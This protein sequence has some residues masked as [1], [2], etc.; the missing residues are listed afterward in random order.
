MSVPS[1]WLHLSVRPLVRPLLRIG[2]RPN[3]VTVAHLALGLITLVAL[4]YGT[5]PAR[6]AAGAGWLISCLL[7]RLDGELARTGNMCSEFGHRLDYLTDM[8][9]ST[10]YFAALGISVRGIEGGA[11]WIAAGLAASVSQLLLM[12]VAERYDRLSGEGGHVLASRWGFDADDALLILGPLA[13]M[14]DSIRAVAVVLAAGATLGYLALF[15]GRLRRL[16]A[17][18]RA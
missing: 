15:R 2:V 13:W 8:W 4:A 5:W 9:L 3:H 14:P 12:Q 6:F 10:L 11:W 16:E 1:S 18:M 17:R 7:D